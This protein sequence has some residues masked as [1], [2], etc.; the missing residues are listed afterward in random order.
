MHSKYLVFGDIEGETC[1]WNTINRTITKNM[2]SEQQLKYIFLGDIFSALRIQSSIDILHKIL[3][4][5]DITIHDC[6]SLSI[7]DVKQKFTDLFKI[8]RIDLFD[9]LHPQYYKT[10]VVINSDLHNELNNMDNNL[11][12][13]YGNKEVEIIAFM[14]GINIEQSQL[15]GNLFILTSDSHRNVQRTLRITLDDLN[16]LYTYLL[17]CRHYVVDGSNIYIHC[18]ENAKCFDKNMFKNINKVISGHSKCVGC[19]KHLSNECFV[20]KRI[21]IIDLTKYDHELRHNVNAIIGND[22]NVV[23]P[24]FKRDY[25]VSNISLQRMY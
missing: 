11:A 16:V 18:F 12:F 3:N 25:Y 17:M 5:F 13:I 15:N 8:K 24:K 22:D 2:Q 10:D 7:E 1:L 23:L 9:P 21:F 4:R 6:I 19:Y 20:D 14:Q